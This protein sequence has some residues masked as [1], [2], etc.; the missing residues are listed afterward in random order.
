[1]LEDEYNLIKN[2]TQKSR[3]SSLISS[4]KK[5][6]SRK[7]NIHKG[8]ELIIYFFDGRYKQNIESYHIIINNIIVLL[9][10]KG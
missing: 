6:K 10:V 4:S 2:V 9:G 5:S 1:M 3:N 7:N 8:M